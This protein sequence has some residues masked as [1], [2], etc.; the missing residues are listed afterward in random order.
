MKILIA[1][2]SFALGALF[3]V[4]AMC[5]FIVAGEED[6]QLEKENKVQEAD[7]E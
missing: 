7:T 6:R 3:G 4:G 2:L 1:I 5:C